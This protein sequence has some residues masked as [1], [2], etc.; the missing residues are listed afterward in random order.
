MI[1]DKCSQ[2]GIRPVQKR[3]IICK[4][5]YCSVCGNFVKGLCENCVRR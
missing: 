5:G 3:C 2:C 1:P 4:R